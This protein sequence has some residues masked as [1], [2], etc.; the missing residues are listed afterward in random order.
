MAQTASTVLASTRG[1]PGGRRL[2]SLDLTAFVE[3]GVGLAGFSGVVV[4][5]SQRSGQLND[6]DRFRVVLLLVCALV[7]AFIG[8]L[9]VVLE[10]FGIRGPEAWRIVG[11]SLSAATAG[12]LGLTIVSARRMSPGARSSLS[13][14]VW[15]VGIGGTVLVLL[16]NGLNLTGWPRPLSFGPIAA[17]LVWYLVLASLMFFRL[18]LVRIGN[19]DGVAQQ[20]EAVDTD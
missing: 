2:S 6:Y 7:P 12:F 17:T 9:P 3:F 1:F 4:A 10:G 13:P 11:A 16:W 8:T 18:L 20:S 19:R 15:R 14:A 5:F